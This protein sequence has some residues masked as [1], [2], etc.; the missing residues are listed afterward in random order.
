M[1][2]VVLTSKVSNTFSELEPLVL[3][4]LSTPKLRKSRNLNP[5]FALISSSV[6]LSDFELLLLLLK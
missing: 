2:F 1:D 4:P 5:N 3:F 6:P